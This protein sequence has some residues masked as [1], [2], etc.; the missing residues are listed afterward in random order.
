V[1]LQ[2]LILHRLVRIAA[3]VQPRLEVL[4]LPFWHAKALGHEGSVLQRVALGHT[5]VLEAAQVEGLVRERMCSPA[6][7][8]LL[9]PAVA[10]LDA[11]K[12]ESIKMAQRLAGLRREIRVVRGTPSLVELD[13]S[14]LAPDVDQTREEARAADGH[15]AAREVACDRGQLVLLA[16]AFL[17]A[18]EPERSEATDD[19]EEYRDGPHRVRIGTDPDGLDQKGLAAG[20][21]ADDPDF[22][23]LCQRLLEKTAGSDIHS[24]DED[25]DQ[26]AE[27]ARLVEQE[28]HDR[29]LV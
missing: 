26:T 10:P 22:G 12:V 19:D 16:Q 15:S 11:P 25:V 1:A 7:V 8:E 21:R 6:G 5:L 17:V 20:D 18:C 13:T 29:E 2:S 3:L 28:V 14:G 4:R 24:V 9:E 23:L 27:L